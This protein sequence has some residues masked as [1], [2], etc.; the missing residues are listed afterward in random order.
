MLGKSREYQYIPLPERV[1]VALERYQRVAEPPSEDAFV[2]PTRHAPSKYAAVRD[3]LDNSKELLKDTNVDELIREH[4]IVVPS[5]STAGAR[6]MLQRL[7][8]EARLEIDGEY[9][10]STVGGVGLATNSTR[11]AMPNSPKRR[12]DP[13][14]SR[15]PTKR[16]STS[17]PE[18]PRRE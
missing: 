13:L 14:P 11:K 16:T 1:C 8:E 3:Q 18:R 4:E 15:Q 10:K 9:L 17:R 2:F 6:N 12:Y 7:C 5:I